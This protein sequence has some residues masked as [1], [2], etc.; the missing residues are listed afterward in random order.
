MTAAEYEAAGLYDP[1]APNAAERLELLDWLASRGITIETIM[2]AGGAG[3]LP[4]IAADLALKPGARYSFDEV[5]KQTGMT[6]ERVSELILAVGLPVAPEDAAFSS[7]DIAIFRFFAAGASLFGEGPLLRFMRTVGFSLSRIAEA[8]V[9]LFY[10]TVEGPLRARGT[11][12][13]ELA[14]AGLRAVES[15]D[16]LQHIMH[17]VFR[18]HMA[19][20]VERFR[21]AQLGLSVHTARMTVGF[22]DLVGFTPLSTKLNAGDLADMIERFEVRAYD[23]VVGRG[24]RLVK[25]IGDEVMF[26]TL[27]AAAACDIALTICEEFATD[28]AVRPRGALA[29][30]DLIVRGGDYYGPIVNL[31]SRLAQLAVPAELLVTPAV[32]AEVRSSGLR[33]APA[34]RRMLKGIDEPVALLSVE[35]ATTLSAA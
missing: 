23:V 6:P 15:V 35:R 29:I 24:G 12:E 10:V 7:E 1:A 28:P 31:A 14:E 20:A 8:G 22:I 13:R 5:V 25:L 30:G 17:Q 21:R 18:S 2:R 3:A 16:P 27:D 4:T 33:F 34:G 11:T 9:S 26:V 32:A 19:A